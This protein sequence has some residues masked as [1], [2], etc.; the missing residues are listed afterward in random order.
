[1]GKAGTGQYIII[2][3]LFAVMF[4]AFVAGIIAFVIQFRKRKVLHE[5]EKQLIEE[6]HQLELLNAKLVSQ[7]Q[8]M[9]HI[10]REI[11]D[12]V[13]QKLTLAS[14]YA[15]R[16]TR[17]GKA[18]AQV[19]AIGNIIDTCMAELRMLSKTLTNPQQMDQDI[20]ALLQTEAI[21][22]NAS[23]SCHVTIDCNSTTI[24]I[25]A[26]QK[27]ILYRLLQEFMQNSLKHAQCRK[28]NIVLTLANGQL[29]VSASDDGKGFDTIAPSGG[30]GLQNMS[31]RAQELNAEYDLTSSIGKGT[32]LLLKLPLD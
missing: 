9:R 23:G 3:I 6:A 5:K 11:H 30:I 31:R 4:A 17:T 8:T 19:D 32:V 12:N 1:M 18:D 13:G 15:R 10:G 25:A 22:I 20:T 27:N 7:Q 28:I 29:T 14:L 2:N 21:Q 26:E 16:L 24:P